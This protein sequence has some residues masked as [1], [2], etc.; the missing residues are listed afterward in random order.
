M[1][2]RWTVGRRDR[3]RPRRPS[4]EA[5]RE[6]GAAPSAPRDDRTRLV[7]LELVVP[8]EGAWPDLLCSPANAPGGH[9]ETNIAQRPAAVKRKVGRCFYINCSIS[10]NMRAKRPQTCGRVLR[11]GEAAGTGGPARALSCARKVGRLCAQRQ[12]RLTINQCRQRPNRRANLRVARA[13]PRGRE[14]TTVSAFAP[15]SACAWRW[16]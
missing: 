7:T 8:I 1:I 15:P 11:S 12:R 14:R 9:C 2:R 6:Q 16:R 4:A 13:A 10:A 5:R 3:A